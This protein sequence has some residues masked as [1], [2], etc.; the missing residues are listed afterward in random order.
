MAEERGGLRDL[1][2]GLLV[3]AAE[4]L[5]SYFGIGDGVNDLT[6]VEVGGEDDEP[7]RG[8][9]VAESPDGGVQPPP[10]CV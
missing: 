8:Q 1:G 7:R 4:G 5:Y 6:V 9:P 10:R 3:V 2:L